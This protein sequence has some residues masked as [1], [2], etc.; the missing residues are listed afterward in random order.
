LTSRRDGKGS[1]TGIIGVSPQVSHDSSTRPQ[2]AA[3]AAAAL[4]AHEVAKIAIDAPP[5]DSD[6]ARAVEIPWV[7]KRLCCTCGG[8]WVC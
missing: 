2:V 3:L 6:R 5:L 4:R 7:P 8:S 1:R